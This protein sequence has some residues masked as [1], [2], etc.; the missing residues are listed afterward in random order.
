[1][2]RTKITVLVSFQGRLGLGE[3]VAGI[4]LNP[5]PDLALSPLSP[6]CLEDGQS[7]GPVSHVTP[8]TSQGPPCRDLPSPPPSFPSHLPPSRAQAG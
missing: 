5:R 3:S 6:V 8:A 4:G 2:N 7:Q 1:M